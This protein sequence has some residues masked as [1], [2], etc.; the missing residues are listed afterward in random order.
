MYAALKKTE[1]KQKV[2]IKDIISEIDTD[3]IKSFIL[4]YAKN[5]GAFEIAFKSHFISRISMGIDESEKYKRIL[6]EIIKPKNAYN[7]KIN[8]ALK[9]TISIVMKDLVLQMHDCLSSN[10][11]TEAYYLI[12]ECLEKIEYLQHRYFIKEASLERCRIQLLN[13]L[14]SILDMELAPA[15]R[16][17]ME[18]ELK[19]L[20]LKSYFF[21]QDNN[22]IELLNQKNVFVQED[23]RTISES[24]FSKHKI[25]PDLD[26]LT[27][28]L[29]QL[30]HPFDDLAQKVV[31]FFGNVKIFTSLKSIIKEGKF[32]YADFLLDNKSLNLNVNKKILTVLK[33]IEKQ[34]FETITTEIKNIDVKNI[35]VIELRSIIDELP[36]VY[37]KKEF[38]RIKKWVDGLPFGLKTN[39][40]FHAGYHND[41]ISMLEIKNDV[42]WIKVYDNELLNHGYSQ[43]IKTLYQSTMDNYLEN[44]L[45]TKAK[46]YVVKVKQHLFKNG[47]HKIAE[48]LVDHISNK[49]SYRISLN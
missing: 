49:F 14:E 23:K 22:L 39:L 10:N 6:D 34:E 4:Q 21:P 26:N 42:E 24:L 38:K 3:G 5:D 48:D 28:T 41:L 7:Q 46:E 8:P 2:K 30:A 29:I 12:K 1:R 19:E 35:P 17:K 15:F 11:Y 18:K 37:L 40:Y 16:S 44:H 25:T 31:T 36:E 43:E 9:K 45:G 20:C 13:G 27:K 32:K 33:L 47:H